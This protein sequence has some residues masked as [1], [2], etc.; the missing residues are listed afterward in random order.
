MSVLKNLNRSY[1]MK[2]F[3]IALE[4]YD[5]D[6]A[7]LDEEL[8]PELVTEEDPEAI[9]SEN[10]EVIEAEEIST[11]IENDISETRR[12]E[13]VAEALESLC[14][15][16]S[17]MDGPTPVNVALIKLA[18]N[19]GVAGTNVDA[20]ALFSANEDF[21]DL[22]VTVEGIQDKI[23]SVGNAIV[24]SLSVV[25]GKIMN[26][27]KTIISAYER[28]SKRIKAAKD[29]LTEVKKNKVA[30]SVSLVLNSNDGM[31]TGDGFV[32]DAKDYLAA[33]KNTN[34]TMTSFSE[35][36]STQIL[37]LGQDS[38]TIFKM[39]ASKPETVDK[40]LEVFNYY[41]KNFFGKLIKIPGM[42]KTDFPK[43]MIG[44][45]T[46]N[47]LAK[48]ILG[49]GIVVTVPKE[50]DF[51][52]SNIAKIKANISKYHLSSYNFSDHFKLT[53]EKTPPKAKIEFNN[54]QITY[55]EGL[56]AECEKT[57]MI[58]KTYSNR[59]FKIAQFL[60]SVKLHATAAGTIGALVGSG[61]FAASAAGALG[62]VAGGVA[63]A[64]IGAGVGGAIGGTTSAIIGGVSTG[65]V[66][67]V[68]GNVAGQI[69]GVY[70]GIKVTGALIKFINLKLIT[71]LTYNLSYMSKATWRHTNL[72]LSTGLGICDKILSNKEWSAQAAA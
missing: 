46:D 43:E 38:S 9:D 44:T 55:V 69:L 23:K 54:I 20:Q 33:F 59:Q 57:L 58:A 52:K 68:A 13:D 50:D 25:S 5:E 21:T 26:F 62:A 41:D 47:Y 19:M 29:K 8:D 18:A 66:G 71:N 37:K 56:L 70:A 16:I 60:T 28:Y 12:A 31:R 15:I 39:S 24:N 51:D 11:D 3:F 67:A 53:E 35:L 72:M 14:E 10:E 64:G 48:D 27:I 4:E 65:I 49:V 40:F 34:K 1:K 17:R 36:F 6:V 61:Y 32:N 22:K 7:V 42:V 45:D 30:N 2:K 63:G